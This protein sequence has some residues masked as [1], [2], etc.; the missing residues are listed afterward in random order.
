MK[1][2]FI[3]LYFPLLFLLGCS[4]PSNPYSEDYNSSHKGNLYL[5]D[6]A[7]FIQKDKRWGSQ[8]LGKTSD[9]IASDGCLLTASAMALTNLGFQLNP[10]KL[11]NALT[12]YDGFTSQGWLIWDGIR[13]ITGGKAKATVYNTVSKQI[14]DKCIM[15][16]SYP[17]VQFDNLPNGRSHWAMVLG[18]NKNIYYMRD[19]LKNTPYPLNFPITKQNLNAFKSVRCIGLV[20]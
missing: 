18:R 6:R 3:L 5:P 12:R 15:S 7:S 1:N 13:R 8:R 2:Y 14:I 19:P 4:T 9:T 11:N 16:G 17:L 20:D 10:S